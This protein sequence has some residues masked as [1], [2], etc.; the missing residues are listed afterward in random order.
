MASVT[1][2]TAERANEIWNASIVSGLIDVN[3]QLILRTRGGTNIN[4]GAVIAPT[5]A[6]DKAH[7]V[8]SLYFTTIP[9]NPST[10]LGVGTW[11]A[12]GQGRVAVGLDPNDIDFNTVEEVGGVKDVT[13]TTAQMP[14]HRHTLEESFVNDTGTGVTS[15]Q[16]ADVASSNSGTNTGG[17]TT[18]SGS[19]QP[20]ENMPP[21]ITCYMWKRTA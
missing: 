19:S 6:V 10:V 20:H 2:I 15:M 7:P 5:A 16:R 17:N 13:L 21:Y 9:T 11:V 1:G 14:A 18:N 4:A 3:G 12:W 8:G